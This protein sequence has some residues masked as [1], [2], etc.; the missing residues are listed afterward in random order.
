MKVLGTTWKSKYVGGIVGEMERYHNEPFNLI[1][2]IN[3]RVFI[4]LF[5]TKIAVHL[6]VYV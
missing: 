1:K 3:L 2:E 4:K 6:F 5:K